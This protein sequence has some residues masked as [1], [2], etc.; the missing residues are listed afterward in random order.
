MLQH[1]K[2]IQKHGAKAENF[3]FHLWGKFLNIENFTEDLSL[4]KTKN[5]RMALTI[6]KKEK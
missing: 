3:P 4:F 6:E 5:C 2:Y 1:L